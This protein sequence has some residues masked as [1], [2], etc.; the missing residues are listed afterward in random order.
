MEAP[1]EAAPLQEIA[2]PRNEDGSVASPCLRLCKLDEQKFCI[3]C[4]RHLDEIVAWGRADE[5]YKKAV[6][7]RLNRLQKGVQGTLK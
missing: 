5:S 1:R 7:Q 3:A 2:I 6:W 4:H